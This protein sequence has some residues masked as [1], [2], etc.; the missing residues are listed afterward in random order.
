MKKLQDKVVVITGGTRGFGFVVAKALI[1]EGAKV[2]VASRS[3]QSVERAVAM[4]QAEGGQA[5]GMACNVADLAQIK[6]LKTYAVEMYNRI[7]VWINNAGIGGPYGPTAHIAPDV[8]KSVLDTN[9]YG[10]YY[11]SWIAVRH[12]L[13][14]GYGKLINLLGRGEKSPVPMQ[15]AYAS[16]KSWARSFTLALAKEYK[17]QGIGIYALN[18]GMMATELLTQVD[19]VAGYEN[20]LT[21]LPT[22]IRIFSKPPEVPAQKI[23]WLASA[24]TDGRTGLILHESD[25]VSILM[26]AMREGLRRVFRRNTPEITLQVHTIPA[27]SQENYS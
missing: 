2:V 9:I 19:V 13:S 18:P 11:G 14:Q 27:V 7:D 10:T 3:P 20:R 21:A 5:Q 22:V 26:G 25:P 6:K 1:R 8:L 17:D 12:F 15:N 4:L 24:A 16:S 23:V